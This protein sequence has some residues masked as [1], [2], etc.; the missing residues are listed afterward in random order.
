MAIH[1]KHRPNIIIEILV[2]HKHL[3]VLVWSLLENL[4]DNNHIFRL[5]FKLKTLY[6][7]L[8]MIVLVLVIMELLIYYSYKMDC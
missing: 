2:I 6:N 3:N 4:L 5:Y 1:Y 8:F 7:H